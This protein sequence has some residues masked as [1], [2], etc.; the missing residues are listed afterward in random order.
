MATRSIDELV[1]EA[2]K[3]VRITHPMLNIDQAFTVSHYT[4]NQKRHEGLH[5]TRKPLKSALHQ[6][7]MWRSRE[8][9][10]ISEIFYY[11]SGI[12]QTV[13]RLDPS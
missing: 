12:S 13:F 3:L 9:E 6:L 11:K 2:F 4:P 8:P 5:A 1:E 10:C 7:F